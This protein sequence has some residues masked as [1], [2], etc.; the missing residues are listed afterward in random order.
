MGSG[1][2]LEAFPR[3]RRTER[4]RKMPGGNSLLSSSASVTALEKARHMIQPIA[5]GSE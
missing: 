1:V 4:G 3:Y 2:S 5:K